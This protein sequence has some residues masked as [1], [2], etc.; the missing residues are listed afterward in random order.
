MGSPVNVIKTAASNQFLANAN[1]QLVQRYGTSKAN[2]GSFTGYIFDRWWT[3]VFAATIS[4][5]TSGLPAGVEYAFRYAA[6]SSSAGITHA[7][8]LES[9][10]VDK[11]KGK[12]VTFSFYVKRNADYAANVKI[13]IQKNAVANTATGTWT[14]VAETIY[15]AAQVPTSDWLLA[16]V[17]TT[18]P[19]DGSANGLRLTYTHNGGTGSASAILDI[20][21][22]MLNLGETR[23]P[24]SLF[25]SNIV[26]E[27][28]FCQRYFEKSWP[29]TTVVGSFPEGAGSRFYGTNSLANQEQ[30]ITEFAVSKRTTP[31]VTIY[32]S[33]TGTVNERRNY[34]D[35]TNVS[36]SAVYASEKS[37]NIAGAT[38]GNKFYGFHFTAEAEL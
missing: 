20:H 36:G 26:D 29:I 33:F 11:L 5:I 2:P 38:T 16:T 9:F 19:N 25:T 15:L 8:P 28:A 13:Q 24:W 34:T 3:D 35:L 10:L 4:R 37:F 22:P 1:F 14:T 6:T 30:N 17:T 12:I 23:L 18:I 31:V 7:Q 32:N 27:I 21:S